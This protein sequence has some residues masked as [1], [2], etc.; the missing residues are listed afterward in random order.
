MS[1]PEER[2]YPEPDRDGRAR[3]PADDWYDQEPDL[4]VDDP[5]PE[6]GPDGALSEAAERQAALDAAEAIQDLA[7]DDLPYEL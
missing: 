4:A 6:S 3:Q 1:S 5:W 2:G 7:E